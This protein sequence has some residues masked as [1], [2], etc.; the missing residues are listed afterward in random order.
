MSKVSEPFADYADFDDCVAKNQDKGDPEAY[1]ATIKR[2][3]EGEALRHPDF[4][5]ILDQFKQQLGEEQG[6]RR[7]Q[8]WVDKLGL[9]E[10]K[11]YLTNSQMREK[12]SWVRN[13]VDFRLWK[14]DADAKYW[15]VE[16]GFPLQSMNDNVYTKEELLRGARTIKG[17]PVN[18]NHKF[19]L[20]R[21]DI[22]AA[23]YEDDVVECVLR[24]PKILRCPICDETKT[25]NDLIESGRIV[26]VSLE[27][28]CEYGQTSDGACK[29]LNFTGLALLTKEVLPGIPLTRLTPLESIMV[30]A[31]QADSTKEKTKLKKKIELKIVEKADKVREIE[32]E[33][34]MYGGGGG[35]TGQGG[36]TSA[37]LKTEPEFAADMAVLTRGSQP[38]A[39]PLTDTDGH[40]CP[41]GYEFNPETGNC[42]CPPENLHEAGDNVD[43]TGDWDACIN[44]MQSRGYTGD[45]PQKICAAIKNRTV[46][47]AMAFGLA[48]TR[49]EAYNHVLK[50]CRDDPLFEYELKKFMPGVKEDDS[51]TGLGS[52]KGGAGSPLGSDTPIPSAK[53][54]VTHDCPPGTRWSEAD[55]ECVNEKLGEATYHTRSLS[56]DVL[57]DAHGQCP[58]GMIFNGELGKCV[59]GTSCPEGQHWNDQ[60]GQCVPDTQLPDTAKTLPQRTIG[61]APTET[62]AFSEEKKKRYEAE[63]ASKSLRVQVE[64]WKQRWASSETSYQK[65]AIAHAE[66]EKTVERFEQRLKQANDAKD[67]ITAELHKKEIDLDLL[68]RHR[69]EALGKRDEAQ[70]HAE[71]LNTTLENYKAKHQGMLTK[72]LELSKKLTQANEDYLNVAKERDNLAEALKRAQILGKKVI[73]ITP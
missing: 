58:E 53:A 61:K 40:G 21:I 47:H 31:L 19:E 56:S 33:G 34:G 18:L 2:Q 11:S 63:D 42:N 10:S 41:Q 36:S 39:P 4:K 3:V 57:P 14:E 49:L 24:V 71:E 6:G 67:N 35:E 8:E 20:N 22:V 73:R 70:R 27:A 26:N 30:E 13:H 9:D 65:E 68:Q 69:D 46:T 32:D 51:E 28:T 72:N 64:E 37:G 66:T 50:K 12:F 23:D 59:Q 7:Y 16:A 38:Q 1:C 62:L 60:A 25:V 43:I 48:K 15:R 17:K 45:S 54:A 55:Q 44:L 52:I 29:G 5:K